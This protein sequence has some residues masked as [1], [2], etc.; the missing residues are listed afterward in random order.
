ME[1]R[2]A[3]VV[4][5]NKYGIHAR[6]ASAIVLAVAASGCSAEI[7]NLDTGAKANAASTM[8]LLCFEAHARARLH[9]KISGENAGQLLATLVGLFESGFG[10]D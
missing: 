1:V 4:V 10:E 9:L 8:E 6:P 2:E 3:D 7:T 5:I